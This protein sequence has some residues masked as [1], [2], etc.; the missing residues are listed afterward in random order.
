MAIS[1]SG[2]RRSCQVTRET[3]EPG[4]S[5]ALAVT[6]AASTQTPHPCDAER[7]GKQPMSA[8]Y[9]SMHGEEHPILSSIFLRIRVN[10]TLDC[11]DVCVTSLLPRVLCWLRC[12]GPAWCVAG[13]GLVTG[14]GACLGWRW[15]CSVGVWSLSSAAVSHIIPQPSGPYQP[16]KC[17]QK[18]GE[19]SW[20]NIGKSWMSISTVVG[21]QLFLNIE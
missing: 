17:H 6:W 21:V 14:A 1:V 12:L 7:A 11:D 4:Y 19:S 3:P 8:N 2:L 10:V 15:L 16:P 5:L 18:S 13:A 20:L 9:A